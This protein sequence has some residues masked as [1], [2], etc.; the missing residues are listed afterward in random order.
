[1]GI[2]CDLT[3]AFD[4]V[5]HDLLI[6]KLKNDGIKGSL[7]KVL[8]TYK[9]K[10]RI[11]LYTQ[12]SN[13]YVSKWEISRHGVPQGS[14]LGPLLFNVYINDLSRILNGLAHT[15]LYADDTTIIVS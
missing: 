2:F 4:C 6:R 13:T 11:V 9:R 8:E 1:V 15:A 10:Q 5:N 3:K 7:L 12:D 14:V